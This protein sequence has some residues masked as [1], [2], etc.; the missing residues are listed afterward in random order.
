MRPSHHAA[1]YGSLEALRILLDAGADR[2]ARNQQAARP[3]YTLPQIQSESVEFIN[4]SVFHLFG[5]TNPQE[6]LN[7][8]RSASQVLNS[9]SILSLPHVS[10]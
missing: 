3:C 2:S 6:I 8:I 5:L 1:L 7:K 10:I 9:E 4:L